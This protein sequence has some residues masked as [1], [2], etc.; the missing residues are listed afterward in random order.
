MKIRIIRIAVWMITLIFIVSPGF[1]Q[2]RGSLFIIGGGERSPEMLDQLIKTAKL[3][4]SDRVVILPMA[5][6]VPVETVRY[7]TTELSARIENPIRSFNFNRDQANEQQNWI[8][9]VRNAKLIYI[10]GGDQNRF[11]KVV[12][13]TKL[14][15]ALHQAYENGAT[16]SGTSAGAAVMSQLMITGEEKNKTGKNNFEEIKTDNVIITEGLGF[17]PNAIID[18]HFI[19]RS[20]YN[21]LLSVLAAHPEKKVIGIDERTAI[22]VKDKKARVV[23]ESQ[24]VVI[25]NPKNLRITKT[26]KAGFQRASL[27]LLLDGDSFMLN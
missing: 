13:G 26:H 20:R 7:I 12:F 19:V 5:S 9:T 22:I 3:T 16:I 8:D 25:A 2:K 18:Q 14:Y 11:M 24:V 4:P 23:G 17:L 10:T 1:G 6:G 21:R 15:D 27:S